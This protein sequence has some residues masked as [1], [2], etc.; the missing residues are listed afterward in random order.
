MSYWVASGNYVQ[1]VSTATAGASAMVA[2][3][4]NQ[5]EGVCKVYNIG[6][7]V[8]IAALVSA[9]GSVGEANYVPIP[10]EGDNVVFYAFSGIGAKVLASNSTC[11]VNPGYMLK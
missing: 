11:L 7:R 3:A 4:S 1:V 10:P 5:L 6:T 8:A 9:N 2:I